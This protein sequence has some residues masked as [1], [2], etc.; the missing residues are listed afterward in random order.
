MDV[1]RVKYSYVRKPDHGYGPI[2]VETDFL[3]EKIDQRLLKTALTFP[4]H[5]EAKGYTGISMK[6]RYIIEIQLVA[7]DVR[8]LRSAR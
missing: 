8:R 3:A 4:M 5:D 6:R 7:E 2:T 1:Y